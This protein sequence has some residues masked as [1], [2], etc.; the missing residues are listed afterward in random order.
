LV[1][2]DIELKGRSIGYCDVVNYTGKSPPVEIVKNS[3]MMMM[4]IIIK[5]MSFVCKIAIL[6][7]GQVCWDHAES[8]PVCFYFLAVTLKHSQVGT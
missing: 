3:L 1:F 2:V 7:V 8:M 4:I 6:S 5:L